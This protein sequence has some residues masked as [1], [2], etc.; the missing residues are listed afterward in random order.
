MPEGSRPSGPQ[1]TLPGE[2]AG[3]AIDSA[4]LAV[5]LAGAAE[6]IA[7]VLAGRSLTEPLA[8]RTRE[9]PSARERGALQDLCYGTLRDYGRGDFFIARLA[10]KAVARPAVRA[11]LLVAL[12]RLEARPEAA[13]TTVDQAVDAAGMLGAAHA[14][15]FVNALLRNFLRR[16]EELAD[17]AAHDDVARYR[18]PRW[19]LERLRRDHPRR[20]RSIA[21]A[22]NTHPPMALR[23]N[24]RRSTP[25][26]YLARLAAEGI[27]ARAC[28][29]ACVLLE[30][31]V[32]VARL[33]DFA[34]G[35]VSV[36]D[37]GAQRAGRLLDVRNGMRVLDACAAPGG[38]TAHLLEGA[39]ARVLALD[40]SEARCT[41]IREN[42]AR[43]GL[44]ADVRTADCRELA[45]WWDG[46]PFERILLDAPCSASGVVRRHPDA[47]WLRRPQDIARFGETQAQM[48]EALWQVLAAGGK[49]LYATCSMFAEENEQRIAAF[50]AEH[51][52]CIRLAIGGERACQL[53][54]CEEHDG[55]YYALVGKA[56]P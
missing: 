43:L 37:A 38:K 5:S 48:L 56:R 1:T 52:D 8:R 3:G 20:W 30:R 45:A 9:G 41:S 31:A 2:H 21:E 39:R 13:H 11:L 10:H 12:A 42:L 29:P 27:R 34:A 25:A 23:V 4:A 15:P 19:W 40:A 24:L 50:A 49:L 36:Q 7:E 46:Q 16:R 55:F 32:P 51:A 33:P 44:E 35:L 26:G 17:A 14:K 53:F 54:P 6:A 28:G 47:K 22:G 18:H